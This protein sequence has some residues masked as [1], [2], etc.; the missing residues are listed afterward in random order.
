MQLHSNE[1]HIWH[2]AFTPAMLQNSRIGFNILSPDEKARALRFQFEIHQK[3]FTISRT[4]LRYLLSLYLSISPQEIIFGYTTYRK[5]YV[6][7]PPSPSLYFNLSHSDNTVI[8]AFSCLHIGVDIENIKENYPIGIVERFFSSLEKKA[9]AS[10]PQEEKISGFYRIWSRKEAIIK[11]IGKGLSI[12]LNSFSVSIHDQKETVF[13]N[14]QNLALLP[15]RI[16]T[17]HECSLDSL[18]PLYDISLQFDKIN[19]E[20]FANIKPLEK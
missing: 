14:N 1:I 5:P 3:R 12:P 17:H 2:S 6:K 9:W 7:F 16:D 8:Y 13:L 19:E 10:L 4:L 11:A 20:I 18:N 15:L